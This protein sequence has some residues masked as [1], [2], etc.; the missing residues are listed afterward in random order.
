M[1]TEFVLVPVQ[2][3]ENPIEILWLR[4]KVYYYIESPLVESKVNYVHESV[5]ALEPGFS[6]LWYICL[7]KHYDLAGALSGA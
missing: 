5:S 6:F 3:C 4:K 1:Q 7:A 2:P